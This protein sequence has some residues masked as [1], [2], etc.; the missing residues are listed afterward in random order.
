M[1]ML[2][3]NAPIIQLQ[4]ERKSVNFRQT[5]ANI[6][7]NGVSSSNAIY[8]RYSDNWRQDD[9]WRLS[10]MMMVVMV[11]RNHDFLIGFRVVRVFHFIVRK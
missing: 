6:N 1:I 4:N 3:S 11:F 2:R 5:N 8:A 7:S 9:P 10:V